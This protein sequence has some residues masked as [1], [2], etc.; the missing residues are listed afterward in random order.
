M[1]KIQQTERLVIGDTEKGRLRPYVDMLLDICPAGYESAAWYNAAYLS[2]SSKDITA[3]TSYQRAAEQ[4]NY[5]S[6]FQKILNSLMV[7]AKQTKPYTSIISTQALS[8]NAICDAVLYYNN[9][10]LPQFNKAHDLS[11][12]PISIAQYLTD[13]PTIGCNHFMDAL[14]A[15]SLEQRQTIEINAVYMSDSISKGYFDGE[16]GF[17]AIHQIEPCANPMVRSAFKAPTLKRFTETYTECALNYIAY[18]LNPKTQAFEACGQE[19][20]IIEPQ[21]KVAS[22][23]LGSLATTASADYVKH[24][25]EQGYETVFVFGGLNS[26]ISKRLDKLIASYPHEQQELINKKIVRLGNQSDVEM[27][28]IFTRSNCIVMRGGGLSVMEQ[29]AMPAIKEKIVLMHHE[30]RNDDA[31]LT[32]GLSWEDSNA[33]RLIN[34]LAEQKVVAIKTSPGR[35]ISALK[36]AQKAYEHTESL[37]DEIISDNEP[38]TEP[39]YSLN[40]KPDLHDAPKFVEKQNFFFHKRVDRMNESECTNNMVSGRLS[41][42]IY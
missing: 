26:D 30:D 9:S 2:L 6:V 14:E 8:I 13:L 36:E 16:H 42:N 3:M 37:S 33:D 28:P 32:S 34:Y 35:C 17:K 21:K 23:M 11:Y 12:P 38:L 7:A 27:A 24:L 10:F 19:T 25:L 40:L 39:N 41:F 4:S 20:L 18:K 31:E 22:I 5:S 1:S 29:M 15:L